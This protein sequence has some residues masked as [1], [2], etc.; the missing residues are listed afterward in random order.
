MDE[1]FFRPLFCTVKAE[2]DREQPGLMSFKVREADFLHTLTC[3]PKFPQTDHI[4]S[5][6][7]A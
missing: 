3:D 1:R 7:T 5:T 4:R 6:N 2:L